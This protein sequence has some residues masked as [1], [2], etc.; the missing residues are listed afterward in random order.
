MGD[1]TVIWS[2]WSPLGTPKECFSEIGIFPILVDGRMTGAGVG[3]GEATC[4]FS[5]PSA[6]LAGAGVC[7]ELLAGILLGRMVLV[8]SIVKG[9]GVDFPNRLAS[10]PNSV[11]IASN[12]DGDV[13]HGVLSGTVTQELQSPEIAPSDPPPRVFSSTSRRAPLMVL[14]TLRL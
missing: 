9:P 4:F 5:L 8:R 14:T 7:F 13:S 6:W 3:F 11:F 10:A 12:P 2:M 1:T